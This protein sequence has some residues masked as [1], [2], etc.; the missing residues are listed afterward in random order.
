MV[1][2]PS[3]HYDVLCLHIQVFPV[4]YW[5]RIPSYHFSWIMEY[6]VFASNISCNMLICVPAYPSISVIVINLH[7][8]GLVQDCS[9][10]SVLVTPVFH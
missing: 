4:M 8:G 7:V 1:V 6:T 2:Y 5:M 9:N 3:I 10:S